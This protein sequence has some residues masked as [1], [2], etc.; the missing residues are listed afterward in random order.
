[1]G[2][3]DGSIIATIITTHIANMSRDAT[4]VVIVGHGHVRRPARHIGA[5]QG[6]GEDRIKPRQ[7]RECAKSECG[8]QPISFQHSLEC[9]RVEHVTV[10]PSS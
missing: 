6:C 4:P 5:A 7:R 1:M 10:T 2:V 3:A 9:R 8:D